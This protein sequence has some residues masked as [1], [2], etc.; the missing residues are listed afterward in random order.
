M[1]TGRKILKE[2]YVGF[3]LLLVTFL[4]LSRYLPDKSDFDPSPKEVKA[5]LLLELL[6]RKGAEN[7]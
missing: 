2:F 6:E 7:S 3:L 1:G 4:Y 5:I